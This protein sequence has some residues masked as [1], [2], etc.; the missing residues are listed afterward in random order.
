MTDEIDWDKLVGRSL[1]TGPP[2]TEDLTV[3]GKYHVGAWTSAGMR[4]RDQ[5]LQHLFGMNRT[6]GGLTG[7]AAAA[8]NLGLSGA[9]LLGTIASAGQWDTSVDL[10]DLLLNEDQGERWSQ[11]NPTDFRLRAGKIRGAELVAYTASVGDGDGDPF[12]R[13]YQIDGKFTRTEIGPDGK[14]RAFITWDALPANKRRLFQ[15]NVKTPREALQFFESMS[16]EYWKQNLIQ[17]HNLGFWSSMSNELVAMGGQQEYF[18]EDI[19]LFSFFNAGRRVMRIGKTALELSRVPVAFKAASDGSRV[20]LKGAEATAAVAAG[21]ATMLARGGRALHNL[22]LGSGAAARL[23]EAN[24]PGQML[25]RQQL[26]AGG[27]FVGIDQ[28][29]VQTMTMQKNLLLDRE[30]IGK[31]IAFSAA[32]GLVGSSLVRWQVNSMHKT[33]QTA[34][35]VRTWERLYAERLDEMAS[36][37]GLP[38]R[39]NLPDEMALD[40]AKRL[41][42]DMENDGFSEFGEQ[43]KMSVAKWLMGRVFRYAD[44]IAEGS[45]SPV[46]KQF[47][48]DSSDSMAGAK[49][50]GKGSFV[51]AKQGYETSNDAVG[52]TIKDLVADSGGQMIPGSRE[53]EGMA[54]HHQ[55]MRVIVG[56]IATDHNILEEQIEVAVRKYADELEWP[57]ADSQVS[58]IVK[59]VRI[60]RDRLNE[61]VG[62]MFAAGGVNKNFVDP[63]NYHAVRLWLLDSIDA[64]PAA[65]QELLKSSLIEQG[66]ERELAFL[67][68]QKGEPVL[69]TDLDDAAVTALRER[70]A[71]GTPAVAATADVP[72]QAARKGA[73]RDA[74]EISGSLTGVDLNRS[75][76]H[77]MEGTSAHR[78]RGI[79][80]ASDYETRWT[81]PETGLEETIRASE[82]INNDPLHIL[83]HLTKKMGPALFSAVENTEPFVKDLLLA[84][85]EHF[86]AGNFSAAH[87]HM[88]AAQIAEILSNTGQSD[89]LLV[90]KK[91]LEV[92]GG[93]AVEHQQVLGDSAAWLAI[94]RDFGEVAGESV[95]LHPQT[96]GYRSAEALLLDILEGNT[97]SAAHTARIEKA[98][99]LQRLRAEQYDT[100][101]YADEADRW[102]GIADDMPPELDELVLG[103]ALSVPGAELAAAHPVVGGAAQPKA[104]PSGSTP[105]KEVENALEAKGAV[106]VGQHWMLPTEDLGAAAPVKPQPVKAE[107]TKPFK[108][109]DNTDD[110]MFPV[111]EGEI[112]GVP[113]RIVRDEDAS[114]A[115]L[116]VIDSDSVTMPTGGT[117]WARQ[118]QEQQLHLGSSL[119]DSIEEVQQK[120]RAKDFPFDSEGG[121]GAKFEQEAPTTA[122]H[123]ML[124]LGERDGRVHLDYIHIVEELRRKGHASR[125][126]DIISEVAD[127]YGFPLHLTVDDRATSKVALRK[128]YK[129]HGFALKKKSNDMVR[130]PFEGVKTPSGNKFDDVPTESY[131]DNRG[132]NSFGNPRERQQIIT[133]GNEDGPPEVLAAA[134]DFEE[135]ALTTQP[136]PLPVNTGDLPKIRVKR[137]E[138]GQTGVGRGVWTKREVLAAREA[139]HTLYFYLSKEVRKRFS[140]LIGES[141]VPLSHSGLGHAVPKEA[142]NTSEAFMEGIVRWM[143]G[144]EELLGFAEHATDLP[145]LKAFL[146][147]HA[148]GFRVSPKAR[149]ALDTRRGPLPKGTLTPEQQAAKDLAQVAKRQAA[150]AKEAVTTMEVDVRKT[151]HSKGAYEELPIPDYRPTPTAGEAALSNVAASAATGQPRRLT[152]KKT[153]DSMLRDVVA[154]RQARGTGSVASRAELE[155][156][157]AEVG[158]AVEAAIDR[159]IS[160]EA[161]RNGYEGALRTMHNVQSDVNE[162][163]YKNSRVHPAWGKMLHDDMKYRQPLE[164]FLSAFDAGT[165]HEIDPRALKGGIVKAGQKQYDRA[166]EWQ[167]TA[168]RM[169]KDW[170]ERFGMESGGRVAREVQLDQFK[171]MVNLIHRRTGTEMAS[172]TMADVNRFFQKTVYGVAAV[173]MSFTQLNDLASPMFVLGMREWATE[174]MPEFIRTLRRFK[175]ETGLSWT[176]M[177]EVFESSHH[178]ATMDGLN[179]GLGPGRLTQN[180]VTNLRTGAEFD[181]F[182]LATGIPKP[183]KKVFEIGEEIST[184]VIAHTMH[185]IVARSRIAGGWSAEKLVFKYLKSA[186]KWAEKPAN[187]FQRTLMLSTKQVDLVK[188]LKTRRGAFKRLT[189]NDFIQDADLDPAQ[190]RV[191]NE[192]VNDKGSLQQ[193]LRDLKKGLDAGEDYG[194]SRLRQLGFDTETTVRLAK[195]LDSVDYAWE[196]LPMVWKQRVRT[197]IVQF[198]NNMNPVPTITNTAKWHRSPWGQL[199]FAFMRFLTAAPSRHLPNAMQRGGLGAALAAHAGT[200]AWSFMIEGILRPLAKGEGLWEGWKK[201]ID[202]WDDKDWALLL[203]IVNGN[204]QYGFLPETFSAMLSGHDRSRLAA[205]AAANQIAKHGVKGGKALFSGE[206]GEAAKELGMAAG[207]V[208]G[209]GALETAWKQTKAWRED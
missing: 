71:I 57:I 108:K 197:A 184:Q 109:L 8:A 72:A 105:L 54:S 111:Y 168:Y 158:P 59:S 157:R 64:R 79:K 106:K 153:I 161:T 181:P 34:R 75:S 29:R 40:E 148:D 6:E 44:T 167:W 27:M 83:E 36:E 183:I 191:L 190:I 100:A 42:R 177:R 140:D 9:Q 7:L 169:V 31:Y 124:E 170:T 3:R 195:A 131:G 138:G 66:I 93:L 149:T 174:Y 146:K 152:A 19:A 65:W 91:N 18:A 23:R 194:L 113:V 155:A 17:Q 178:Y 122:G 53:M 33:S 80:M 186:H 173:P 89:R 115:T 47:I 5:E 84:A 160:L 97:G 52:T 58:A 95:R 2:G 137:A 204:G 175:K 176:E 192:A 78:S 73:I 145:A 32:Y 16:G 125:A 104:I 48:R 99:R 135:Y 11:Q 82:F 196:K 159:V 63:N 120:I 121:F 77:G 171:D 144:D 189:V 110:D 147:E 76:P 139:A 69:L 193:V 201:P 188:G 90:F 81:N 202:Q 143:A 49:S 88:V 24:H 39:A 35:H 107:V 207:G 41:L 68:K 112:D 150:I 50:G 28:A 12:L 180:P 14:R 179:N 37:F 103:R 141:V 22:G 67:S 102:G 61:S 187:K 4:R 56:E 209:L 98:K 43:S 85:S 55:G 46:F 25:W 185:P 165:I 26:A 163:L 96:E 74:E 203:R 114:G 62:M 1:P 20:L 119:N 94:G 117:H 208:F 126:L 142:R 86:N 205:Y 154:I 70:L 136:G 116:F 30:E 13:A 162:W 206:Y 134:A 87:N 15:E 92:L 60:F 132:P 199:V 128:F 172:G 198:Q 151:L 200:T 129:G 133:T 101:R 10:P 182:P 166:K 118:N 21:Q 127:E 123:V 156:L 164:E 130:T 45:P 38:S 51:A